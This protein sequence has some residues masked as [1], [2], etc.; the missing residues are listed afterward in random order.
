MFTKYYLLT[1]LING[2]FANV[3]LKGDWLAWLERTHSK[4]TRITVT[5]VIRISKKQH[6]RIQA[7]VAANKETNDDE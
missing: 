6:A 7:I 2:T 4:K 3:V 1:V 5:S